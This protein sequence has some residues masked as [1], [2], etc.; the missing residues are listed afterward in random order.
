MK[1]LLTIAALA[2]SVSATP[3][4]AAEILLNLSGNSNVSGTDGNGRFFTGTNGGTTVNVRVS[5][6][7]LDGSTVRDSFLGAFGPGVGVTSGDDNGGAN[8]LHVIDNQT[9]RDFILLQFDQAVR[10][11]SGTFT[12]YNVGGERDSDATIGF[13]TTTANW[14]NQLAL[15]NADSSVLAAMFSGGVNSSGTGAGGTRNL[16]TGG[17]SGNLWLVA[18]AF[19]DADDDIDGFKF[20]GLLVNTV[21]AVPEPATWGTMLIGF[22]AVG[23]ALRRRPAAK[24]AMA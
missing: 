21:S 17:A 3:A 19:D 18:A 24:L 22:G 10:F 23:S 4:Y 6:W 1:T 7:S 9:R 5:G 12:T 8:N 15:N 16:G 11:A 14:R 13:G 2:C 20:G